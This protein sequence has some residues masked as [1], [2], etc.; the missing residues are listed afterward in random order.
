MTSLDDILN[1]AVRRQQASSREAVFYVSAGQ[2]GKSAIPKRV[3]LSHPSTLVRE[4]IA[5]ILTEGGFQ[6]VAETDNYVGLSESVERFL[7][8]VVLVDWEASELDPD[9]IASLC[10]RTNGAVV[11]LVQP[12][13]STGI[14]PA[15]RAGARGC[16]SVNLSAE[17][18]VESLRVLCTGSV[19]VF[20]QD[21]AGVLQEAGDES[22]EEMAISEREREVIGMVG[23]GASN[24]EIAET[25][26]VSEHTVKVHL[27]NILNKLDLRNRQ[28]IAA[29]AVRHGLVPETDSADPI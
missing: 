24:R 13:A 2:D 9:A 29:Y 4:G 17:D 11:L 7:P 26:V 15:A 5:R 23:Q 27:R 22:R 8:D 20:S 12:R 21:V 28:Q 3:V 16:L 6:V 18:F 14:L 19:V 10:K 1:T 25:L